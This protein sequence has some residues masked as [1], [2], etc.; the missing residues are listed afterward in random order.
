MMLERNLGLARGIQELFL[1][2]LPAGSPHGFGLVISII[3]H[4]TVV[5]IPADL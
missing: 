4:W 2:L 3:K 1:E 5:L